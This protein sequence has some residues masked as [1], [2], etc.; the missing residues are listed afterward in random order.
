MPIGID[1]SNPPGIRLQI[2]RMSSACIAANDTA[3]TT[4]TIAPAVITRR[5]AL[6]LT[7]AFPAGHGRVSAEAHMPPFDAYPATGVQ[8]AGF[9]SRSWKSK[10][11]SVA[12]E[13]A[14]ILAWS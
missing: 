8:R 11:K 4:P 1:W 12:G 14:R 3:P 9:S 6:G 2:A 13:T 10:L 5:G 7:K